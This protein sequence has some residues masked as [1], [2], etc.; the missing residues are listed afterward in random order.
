MMVVDDIAR[1]ISVGLALTSH[2]LM[3][4]C[5]SRVDLE[6]VGGGNMM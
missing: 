2:R 1:L 5:E 3:D 6:E 4:S